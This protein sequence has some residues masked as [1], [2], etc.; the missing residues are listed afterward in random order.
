[1]H[2]DYPEYKQNICVKESKQDHQ[3]TNATY[4]GLIEMKD[5]NGKDKHRKWHIWRPKA[6]LYNILTHCWE[7]LDYNDN[8]KKPHKIF[9]N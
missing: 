3:A 9:H 4:D 6:S 8:R 2:T 1:M 7:V 5:V